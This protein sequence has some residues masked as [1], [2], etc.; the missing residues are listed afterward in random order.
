MPDFP[1]D[2]TELRENFKYFLAM[3]TRW[4]DNDAYGHVNNARYYS[5][6]ENLIMTYLEVEHQLDTRTGAVRCYTAE[7]GCRYHAAV[8]FPDVV[9]A[10]LRVAH[11]GRSSVR[12]EMGL[13]VQGRVEVA[14]TAFV[15]DVYVDAATERPTQIPEHHRSVLDAV[16][17]L[18]PGS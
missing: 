1:M 2:R 13:F 6:F 16:C 7:N 9:E 17:F 15:V 12:Y 11:L 3:P 10:G 8:A 5:L 14:A 4:I 18:S